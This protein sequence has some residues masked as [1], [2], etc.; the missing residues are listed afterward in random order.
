VGLDDHGADRRMSDLS[1]THA[2]PLLGVA[3]LVVVALLIAASI[4]IYRKDM[5][6]QG[7]VRVTLTTTTPGLELNPLS[8]VKLQ[9]VRV[10]EVRRITSDGRF[11]VVEI[12][13][14]PDRV[15]LIP[16]N[17]DAAIVP[18]TLFGEKYVDLLIPDS[19]SK[20]RLGDGDVIRQ[21]TTS[22]E[23]GTLFSKLVPILHALEP[24]K[25]SVVLSSLADALNGRGH[26]IA[27]VLRQL[28]EFLGRVDPHLTTFT[29][30]LHQLA[31][32]TDVY[33]DAAPE[34]IRVLSASAGI[35]RELLVPREQQLADL[36]HQV[37]DTADT[38]A[39]VL[40]KNAQRLITLSGRSRPVLAVLNEYADNLSCL[41]RSLHLV[42][43]LG[44]QSVGAR[45]PFV[46]L[47]VDL[48]AQ[49]KPYTYP[50][51]LP[52]N[53]SSDAHVTNL[54]SSAPSFAPHCAQ[55]APYIYKLKDAAPY[56]QPLGG[57]PIVP[58]DE[59]V[60]ERSA[61]L[62]AAVQEATEAL[63][64]AIAAQLLGVPQEKVPGY[65]ELLLAPMLSDGKVDVP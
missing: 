30:D 64:R 9:G 1:R 26:T 22:V 25:L 50:A 57:A 28:D 60:A 65:A 11:A 8:D 48:V 18:K 63:S 13:V 14:D 24:E 19:P 7:A 5:P 15:D 46:N 31:T 2:K 3:Y 51:D 41:L 55:F 20:D 29:H 44:N 35:S 42:D 53:P 47:A 10:G 61:P 52:S 58:G 6:W 39:A 27:A 32:T 59:A 56:S 23:I 40:R 4:L 34:L 17:V 54:P 43:T 21:S 33:A 45:G 38:T 16:A 36:L 12:A 49:Q 62:D 37:T